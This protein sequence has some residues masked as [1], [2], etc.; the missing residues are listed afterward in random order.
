VAS[1]EATWVGALLGRGTRRYPPRQTLEMVSDELTELGQAVA[2]NVGC[3]VLVEL[4]PSERPFV[5]DESEPIVKAVQKAYLLAVGR[6][7][8]AAGMG[9]ARDVSQFVNAGS[10]PAVY[11]GRDSTTAHSDAEFVEV[12]DLVRC[13]KVRLRAAILYLNGQS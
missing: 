8:P 2:K 10:I 1:I 6:P 5:V 3:H 9:F 13:A 12:A 7:L 11:H 4:Q